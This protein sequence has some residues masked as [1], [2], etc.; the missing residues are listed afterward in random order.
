M[1]EALKTLHENG[2]CH[3][4]LKPSNFLYVLNEENQV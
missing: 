4:D 1:L 2:Y 3:H